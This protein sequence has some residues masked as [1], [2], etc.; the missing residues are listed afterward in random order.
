MNFLET[1]LYLD[2]LVRITRPILFIKKIFKKGKCKIFNDY[3]NFLK[4]AENYKEIVVVASGPSAKN[5]KYD[6]N[7]L[8]I[9]TNSS[10]LLLDQNVNFIH[11]L[12]DLAYLSKFMAFG[13]KRK[14]LKVYIYAPYKNKTNFGY[15]VMDNV[16]KY[17]SMTNNIEIV[18]Q[19]TNLEDQGNKINIFNELKL[20]NDKFSIKNPGGNSGLM[21]L[22]FA[23]LLSIRLNKPISVYGLDAGEGG[24]IYANGRVTN[25]NHIA[26]RDNHKQIMGQY[27]EYLNSQNLKYKNYSYFKGNMLL[28]KEV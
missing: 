18:S 3:E 17:V 24:R 16:K 15:K 19:D 22:D 5:I 1:V 27:L 28:E 8:Y 10:Y 12:N 26:M 9:T 11:I 23:L 4:I 2:T 21:I 25:K 20:M 13:L 7:N 6:K 14:P